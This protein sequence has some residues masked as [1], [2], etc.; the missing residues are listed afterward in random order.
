MLKLHRLIIPDFTEDV[1]LS[2]ELS[3]NP[4]DVDRPTIKAVKSLISIDALKLFNKENLKGL[5]QSG[6][7]TD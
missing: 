4:W 1:L 7:T 5:C 3:A 6:R 2:A